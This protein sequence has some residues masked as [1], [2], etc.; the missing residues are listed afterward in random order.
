M[1]TILPKKPG[2]FRYSAWDAIPVAFGVVH[3]L[4]VSAM[5]GAFTYLHLRWQFKAPLMAAMGI[6]YAYSI[7][8]N[9]NGISHN[10]IHRPF[11]RPAALNRLFSAALQRS[12]PEAG[13]QWAVDG[14]K[15]RQAPYGSVVRIRHKD[16][17]DE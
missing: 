5:Y 9:I 7:S 10:F 3:L 14:D 12:R 1:S 2:L 16:R 4:Y 13:A 17:T 6:A 11:F 15:W 8:W